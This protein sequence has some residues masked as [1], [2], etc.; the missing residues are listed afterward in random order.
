MKRILPV[1][2]ALLTV[3]AVGAQEFTIVNGAEPASLDPH[4]VESVPDHRIYQALFEGLTITDP[5][6][7][8]AI[9][10]LAEKWSFSK[11]NKTVTFNLRKNAVWSDGVKITADTVVKS[12]LRKMDPK[13]AFQYADLCANAIVGGAEY[14][15]GKAGPEGVKI[16]AKD[17][18]TFVVTLVNPTP[19]FADM[20]AHY[21]FAVVPIHAIEKNGADWI[22]PGKFVGNGPFVLEDW[23]PQE[24]VTVVANAKYWDAKNVKLKKITFLPID[25]LNTAWNLYKSGGADWVDTIPAELKDEIKLRKDFHEAPEYGTYYYIINTKRKPLDNADVRKA[26]AMSFDKKEL[27]ANVSKTGVP[28]NSF[29]P[30]SSGYVPAKGFGFNPEEAKKLLAKAGYPDGKGFPAFQILYNTSSS[31]K[32]IAEYIQAQWK[33]VLGIDVSL[34]NQEF[35]T[36]LDTRSQSHDFDIARAG[37]IADYL[38]PSTFS[39]MW[40]TGST[41]NDGQYSNPKYDELI[42][43]AAGQ[44]GDARL[45]TMAE[46]EK[47]LIDQDMAIIPIYFYTTQNVIDLTK[48]DGW[49]ANPMNSHPWKFVGPKKK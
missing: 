17:A 34:V 43:K 14:M 8:R 21:A 7:N 9:G 35:T 10:G 23:K 44:I 38:D 39:D 33:T 20:V 11:D 18:S 12:W 30:P 16:V 28:A 27:T 24:K 32:R 40:V 4:Y 25:D 48:W 29:V 2:F 36:Y 3:F 1:L 47:V 13:N 5:K 46:A 19:H 22:K 26:L 31:H 41:Q 37:W 42:K 15:T 6:T 45:K 49:Y